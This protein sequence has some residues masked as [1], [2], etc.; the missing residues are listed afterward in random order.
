LAES[1]PSL[2]QHPQWRYLENYAVGAH[3]AGQLPAWKLTLETLM[4]EGLLDAV[5]ATSTVAAGVNFPARTVVVLNSDRFDGAGFVPLTATEFHQMTGRAGRRGMDRIGFALMLPG[6]FMNVEAIAELAASRPLPVLSQIKINFSMALNLL[7]SHKPAQIE[8]LLAHSF[9]AF[10]KGRR[11]K[12][13]LRRLVKDF[14][15]HLG[16]LIDQGY[17]TGDGALTEVGEWASQLRVDQPLLIAEC[18]RRELLP[19]DDPALLAAVVASFINERDTDEGLNNRRL[20]KT[21]V[22]VF[23]RLNRAMGPFMQQMADWRFDV[24]PLY[25]RPAITMHL[26]ASERDWRYVIAH[27]GIAEGD[28]A[29]MVLRTAD[30]LR[31]IAS[32]SRVFPQVAQTAGRAIDVILREPVVVE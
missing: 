29:M 2:A 25:L 7:L 31:H 26:W 15:R 10:L 14:D 13:L 20:P 28:L 18:L 9:A 32:L 11:H 6:R 24:R 21:L 1:N 8:V 12:N 5:F 23:V 19:R 16:F 30:H 22:D 17:V 3:H 4:N 27:S